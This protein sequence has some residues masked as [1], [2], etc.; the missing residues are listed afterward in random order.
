VEAELAQGK[1]GGII[2][3]PYQLD[4]VLEKISQA[5]HHAPA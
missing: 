4:D 3:K 2:A 1:L 5:I